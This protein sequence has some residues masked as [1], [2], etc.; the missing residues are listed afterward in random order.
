MSTGLTIDITDAERGTANLIN[1]DSLGGILASEYVLRKDLNK[2]E[3]EDKLN[4]SMLL[5]L[6]HPVGAC[7][8]TSTNSNPG[9]YLGGTWKLIDKVFAPIVIND[10]S[11]FFTTK[12][13]VAEGSGAT[14]AGHTVNVRL[15]CLPKSS[16][17]DTAVNIGT[18]VY[19]QLGFTK[20]D[21]DISG[22]GMSDGANALSMYCI[23]KN[24]GAM[25]HVD[26]VDV[27]SMSTKYNVLYEMYFIIRPENMIDSFCNQF[28]WQRIS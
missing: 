3:N 27:S 10:T 5:D 18:F 19:K 23:D 26:A 7:Y 6:A 20:L 12:L 8:T 25:Q 17:G 11:D 14:I 16:W 22:L 9:N 21:N 2:T 13:T 15:A 24:T 1:A 4:A 28:I